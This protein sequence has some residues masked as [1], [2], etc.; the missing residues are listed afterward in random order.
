MSALKGMVLAA[1][2]ALASATAA[3][4]VSDTMLAEGATI[5]Y[6]TTGESTA[7]AMTDKG[8][9]AL[10]KGAKPLDHGVVIFRHNG[11]LYMAEDPGNAMY[12]SR[13]EYLGN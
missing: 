7:G 13:G 11:K 1:G 4:A 10:L 5:I 3:Y 9:A 8:K 2:L 6:S 12:K